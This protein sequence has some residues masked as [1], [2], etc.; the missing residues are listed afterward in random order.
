MERR[1]EGAA[2]HRGGLRPGRRLGRAGD[3][4]DHAVDAP[5]RRERLGPTSATR[6]RATP[7][8]RSVVASGTAAAD[9]A[10]DFTVHQRVSGSVLEPGEEYYYRFTT[11]I[12]SSPVGRFRTRAPGRLERDGAHR[13]LLLPGVHRRLLRRP[14]R[15]RR[16]GRRPRRLPRRLHLRAGLRLDR[17]AQRAGAHD[18]SAADGEAQTLAEYRRK[19]TLYHTDANLLAAVRQTSRCVGEW[20]DHEVEDNYAGGL[21]GGA[22][23]SRRVPFAERR[24]NG[25]RAWFEHMPRRARAA[26]RRS[27]ARCR[28]ATPSCSCSTRASTAT[29]SRATPPTPRS[30]RRARRRRPTTRRAPCWAPSRRRGSRTR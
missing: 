10:A 15:P 11:A 3:R 30:R 17:L 7:A 18:D 27:T 1:P 22:A 4:R 14:P 6:S 26:S 29:T 5:L 9:A 24:S 28:W 19:Y 16:A 23:K 25:Y 13:L 2:G 21:P 20:D 12:G 8:S